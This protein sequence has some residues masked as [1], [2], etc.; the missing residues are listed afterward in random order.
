MPKKAGTEDAGRV[1]AIAKALIEAALFLSDRPLSIEKL[2][3]LSGLRSRNKVE[4]LVEDLRREYEESGRAFTISKF[5]GESFMLHVKPEWLS[6]VKRHVG[7]TVLSTGVLRTLSFIAY[8]Q[9]VEKSTV[10]AVR[11]GRAYAQVRELTER[12]LIEAERR[13]RST[14][15]KTTKLFA[16]LLGVEDNPA[17]I[18]KKIQEVMPSP[19]EERKS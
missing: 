4:A 18:R 19:E 13:G 14:L 5:R 17:A 7:K 8:H 9:P 3:S 11:G 2:R 12:G 16:E 1:E 10:A 15:L 6:L